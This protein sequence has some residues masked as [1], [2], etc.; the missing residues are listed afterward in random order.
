MLW[1]VNIYGSILQTLTMNEIRLNKEQNI[2][3]K[4]QTMKDKQSTV[5]NKENNQYP[6]KTIF[7]YGSSI[8]FL[9]DYT[10]IIN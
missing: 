10:E 1:V 3:E 8:S 9:L 6:K 7:I 5:N 4:N 2:K